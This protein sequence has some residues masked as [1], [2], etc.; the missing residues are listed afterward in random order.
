MRNTT[1]LWFLA[2]MTTLVLAQPDHHYHTIDKGNDQHFMRAALPLV[3]GAA[4][5]GLTLYTVSNNN[6]S[7]GYLYK[8]DMLSAD[9]EQLKKMKENGIISEKDFSIERK[10]YARYIGEKIPGEGPEEREDVFAAIAALH[11]LRSESILTEAEF[12]SKKRKLLKLL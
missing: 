11:D 4:I 12:E 2:T 5:T 3:L 10:Q 9:V 6:N 8:A 7:T 1:L